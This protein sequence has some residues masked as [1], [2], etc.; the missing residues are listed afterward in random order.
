[1]SVTVEQIKGTL[2]YQLGLK[3]FT[4]QN[5]DCIGVQVAKV[6]TYIN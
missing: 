1:M 5:I 3:N 6:V 2:L 4:G